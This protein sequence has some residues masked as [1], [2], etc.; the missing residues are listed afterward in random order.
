MPRHV[1]FVTIGQSPRSDVTPDILAEIRTPVSVDEF[2]ALD[3]LDD[4]AIQAMAPEDGEERL[5]TRLRDGTEVI[6]GKSRTHARLQ[7]IFARLD[8]Q[9]YDLIVLLCTGHFAPFIV[10]TPFLEPQLVVDNFVRGLSYGA[11]TL[12][13]L[14]PNEKQTDEFHG[15]DG[16]ESR[17]SFA[18]PYGTPRFAEAGH[19]LAGTDVIV[20]HC[21]GYSETMRREVAAAAGRPVLLS[22]RMV[23]HAI[24]LLAS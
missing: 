9:E 1:A 11:R 24:D 22:R 19:E 13:V 4:A 6:I 15:I 8:V 17:L 20:M 3:D 14:V 5:V 7:E 23:A 16:L 2:G 18:T 10:R 12:G 21:M